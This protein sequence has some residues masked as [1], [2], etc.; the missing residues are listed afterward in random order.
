MSKYLANQKLWKIIKERDNYYYEIRLAGTVIDR[1]R[2]EEP[3]LKYFK[4]EEL[5]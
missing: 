4:K 2:I 5:L 1:I 3:A